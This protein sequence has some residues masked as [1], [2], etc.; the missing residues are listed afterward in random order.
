MATRRSYE[1]TIGG[2]LQELTSAFAPHEVRA[3]G[4]YSTIS[5]RDIDQATLFGVIGLVEQ[6]GLELREVRLVD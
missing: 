6:L 5:V 3:N 2:R 1:I 4:M